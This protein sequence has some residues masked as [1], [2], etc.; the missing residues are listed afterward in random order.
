[1][2]DIGKVYTSERDAWIVALLWASVLGTIYANVMIAVDTRSV[3]GTVAFAIFCTVPVL[4]LCIW[5]LFGARYILTH[6]ELL[7]RCGPYRHR[8][9]LQAIRR[10]E[11]RRN[12]ISSPALSL[13]RLHIVYEGSKMG[14][15]ISPA[16]R[17]AFLR[18]LSARAGLKQD[19][20]RLVRQEGTGLRD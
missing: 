9:P 12:P 18:D 13:D 5:I 7:V 11:P 14:I 8:I 2:T 19:G 1:M 3:L 6:K 17:K 15:Y 10:V 16:H 4:V 20:K